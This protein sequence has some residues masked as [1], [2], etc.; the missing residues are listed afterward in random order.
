MFRFSIVIAASLVWPASAFCQRASESDLALS[1][2]QSA[3]RTS[4]PDYLDRVVLEAK[5]ESSAEIASLST[6]ENRS[7]TIVFKSGKT[8][9]EVAKFAEENQFEIVRAEAKNAIGDNG[10]IATLSIGFRDLLIRED[11]LAEKLRKAFGQHQFKLGQIAGARNGREVTLLAETAYNPN[12]LIYTVEVVGLKNTLNSMLGD[13]SV[14]SMLVDED[15]QKVDA[16]E[17]IKAV[18]AEAKRNSNAAPILN[19]RLQDG[20]PPGISPAQILGQ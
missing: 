15:S 19:R 20:P 7:A 13:S 5:A 6:D 18:F 1:A 8:Y 3:F 14:A 11:P 10:R 12:L 2:L 9:D 17:S 4:N 16:Y